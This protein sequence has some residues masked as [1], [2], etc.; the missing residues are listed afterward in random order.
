MRTALALCLGLAACSHGHGGAP[1]PDAPP[2]DA[3]TADTLPADAGY[4]ATLTGNRDRLLA[5]YLAFLQTVPDAAAVE[6]PLRQQRRERLRAVEE[7]RS[8]GAGRV[9]H[10][11]RAAC[12]AA[13]SPPTARSMLD[14][15][16]Q[17][18]PRDRRPGRDGHRSGQLRRR[19][20]QPHDH[21]DGRDAPGAPARR[22]HAP[23]R[24]P[25]RQVRHRRHPGDELLAR[26][27]R[28]RRPA[29]PVRHQRRDRPGRAA[30]PDAV[31]RRSELGGGEHAA[32]PHGPRRRSS[33]RTRSRWTR[34]T[35]ASHNSNPLCT[36]IA[37]R[38]GCLPETSQA[39]RRDL[40]ANY[41]DFEPAWKPTGC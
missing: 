23:G 14:A 31:L 28:L 36:Y 15:R 5:T 6:R 3:A 13:S 25:E 9:P 2:A 32:R 19:R 35:T 17:A 34:T 30:R 41:G 33:T 10:A 29:R 39:R 38:P 20:V 24:A 40:H 26:L 4:P 8:L 37:L 21:V 27:A 1:G 16:H 12:R 18:L 22:Q 11:H 7:A